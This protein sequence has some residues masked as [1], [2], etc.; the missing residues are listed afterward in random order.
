MLSRFAANSS[1]VVLARHLHA[2]RICRNGISGIVGI[3]TSRQAR[4]GKSHLQVTDVD[5]P[6]KIFEGTSLQTQM[7]PLDPRISAPARGMGCTGRGTYSYWWQRERCC[8]CYSNTARAPVSER[9]SRLHVLLEP[10]GYDG[11]CIARQNIRASRVL[12]SLAQYLERLLTC[13][14]CLHF[15]HQTT[16]T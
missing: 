9:C 4:N 2:A 1:P 5:D 3:V 11:A 15:C 10:T 6:D 14:A 16:I 13:N 12:G 8:S 7:H